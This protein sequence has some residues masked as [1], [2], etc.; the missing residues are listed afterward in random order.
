LLELILVIAIIAIVA[1][2]LLPA[3]GRSK[4]K[5]QQAVCRGN[6]HQ[7]GIGLQSF[8]ADNHAYPTVIAPTN[9]EMPGIWISQL[10]SGGFGFGFSKPATNLIEKGVWRCPSAPRFMLPPNTETEFSSYGYNSFGV[11]AV[12]DRTNALGLH[13]RFISGPTNAEYWSKFVAVRESEVVAPSDMIAIGDDVVGGIEFMRED[14]NYLTERGAVQRHTGKLN[15]VFCDGHVEAP[16][17]NSLFVDTNDAA[18]VRWNR[19]HQPH[20][21]KL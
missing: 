4:L 2:L 6:L 17:L 18:L 19:D 7:V 14:M 20:R 21:E 15:V 16:T 13:G 11:M 1:A 5:A 8:V 10:Q 9:G 12:G 3:I